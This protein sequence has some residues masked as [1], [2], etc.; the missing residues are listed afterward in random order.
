MENDKRQK[1]IFALLIISVSVLFIGTRLF[2]L[3]DVPFGQHRMHIDELGAF[4][5]AV[6]LGDYGVD[7]FQ[8][9]FPVYFRCFGEGQNAL[10]TYLAIIPIKLGGI[11][12]FNFRL[13]A[14]ICALGAFASLF[15]LVRQML[16]RW[17][18][19]IALA[20]MTVM[21]VFMMS[22]H[23]GLEAYLFMSF[24]I[25]SMYFQ[26][27]AIA[28]DKPVF[29][30]L[31]G[32]FWGLSLYTY[33]MAYVVV[34]IFLL[35][36]FIALLAYR[37]LTLKN[38]L[39]AGIPFVLLGIPLF[40]QQL[41]MMGALEPFSFMGLVDFWRS[42]HWRADEISA[43]NIIVNLKDSFRFTYV[44]DHQAYD[45]DPRFGTMY[46]VSIPFILIGM[47]ASA[48]AVI[49]SIRARVMDPWLFVWMYYVVSRIFY[50]FIREP[51]INRING[52]FP[53]YLLFAVY[54][55]KAAFD[56]IKWKKVFIAAVFI[57]Y[58]IPFVLFSR[59]FYS[60]VGLI[61][62]AYDIGDSLGCDLQA[63]EAAALAKRIANGKPVV[64]M[65]NDGWMK[66]LS[67][68][69]YTETSPYDFFRDNEPQDRSFNGVEWMMPDELDLSGNTVYLIDNELG[70]IT[71]YLATEGFLGDITYPNYT[72][73]YK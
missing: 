21:P 31:A 47:A 50:L 5:D 64:A 19:A 44:A 1:L 18:G 40:V 61:A 30:F 36:T 26:M 72:I 34:P 6:C 37:K 24:V 11:S 35:L 55:I 66:H 10:Y 16:D 63:G 60:H 7:Q 73:V 68:A 54:G 29:Y 70:H 62:D 56:K 25:I 2:R 32:L 42:P 28:S 49:K 43:S 41:V 67:V 20:L 22:E 12:I 52:I 45:A 8:M 3:D 53:V 23:W 69:L 46:Y 15:F 48:A 27:H 9:H 71:A 13:P 65:M 14:V 17:A 38:A 58:I 4:Y 33:S 57:A 51:N 39:C 59:Y